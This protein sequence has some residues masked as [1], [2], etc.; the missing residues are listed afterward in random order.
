MWYR[1]L[2]CTWSRICQRKSTIN[3]ISTSKK[4]SRLL[5]CQN[6]ATQFYRRLSTRSVARAW[7]NEGPASAGP[8]CVVL[9]CLLS[10]EPNLSP[11]PDHRE[12]ATP[13]SGWP[14]EPWG[15]GLPNPRGPTMRY[16]YP[17]LTSS[18]PSSEP[19]HTARPGVGTDTVLKRPSL[20]LR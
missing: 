8:R 17:S 2:I 11:P 12:S 6:L 5:P 4:S 20:R 7:Q 15:R 13:I 3:L 19:R 16:G 1:Y 14:G 18:T 9:G 10:V